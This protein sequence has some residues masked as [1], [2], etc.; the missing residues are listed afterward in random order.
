MKA[1]SFLRYSTLSPC[2]RMAADSS[3][4]NQR[5]PAENHS[6]KSI[7]LVKSLEEKSFADD[8]VSIL[9]DMSQLSSK[10]PELIK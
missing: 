1:G 9:E 3:R 10:K 7:Y 6:S 8:R 2:V 5:P 4:E